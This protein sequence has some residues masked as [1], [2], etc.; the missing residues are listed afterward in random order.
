M[1]GLLRQKARPNQTLAR[2]EQTLLL[3]KRE[4]KMPMEMDEPSVVTTWENRTQIIKI[5]HSAREMSQELQ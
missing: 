1:D 4:P 2:E 3:L 5:M